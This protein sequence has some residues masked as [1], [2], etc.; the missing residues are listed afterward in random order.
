LNFHEIEA[1]QPKESRL[2]TNVKDGLGKTSIAPD[3]S[4]VVP[5]SGRLDASS[6]DDDSTRSLALISQNGHKG[7]PAVP[8]MAPVLSQNDSA[9]S[10]VSDIN[11]FVSARS[12]AT[13]KAPAEH[14]VFSRQDTDLTTRSYATAASRPL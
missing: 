9:Y 14:P 10:S 3:R 12:T 2:A 8:S 5:E 6:D 13:V 7:F 11:S 1:R 4:S